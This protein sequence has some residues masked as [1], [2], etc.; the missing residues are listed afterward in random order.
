MTSQLTAR[1]RLEPYGRVLREPVLRRILI[2]VLVSGLG[3]GMAVVA[4]AWLAIQIAPV[5][6]R[7]L[8]TGA[9]VAAYAL[10]AALGAVVL[11]PF[12]RSLASS[13]L[14]ALDAILRAVALGAVAV[15]G[16]A[17]L[18]HPVV[19]VALLA[20][21]SLLHAWG[22]AGAYTLVSERLDGAD[23]VTGNALLSTASQASVVIGPA[24]AGG[25]VAIAGPAWVVGLDALS[26][27]ALAA[28]SWRVS[29]GTPRQ[30]ASGAGSGWRVIAGNRQLVGL[31]AITC[32]FYFLY[33]PVEVALPLHV[34]DDLRGSAG[35]LGL[36]L[37][38]F[39][40]GAL[41][42]GLAAGLLP[43]RSPWLV[44][45]VIIVGWGASLLPVGLTNTLLP[46]MI[47]LA[48]G[49]M[50]YGPYVAMSTEL[51]QR[52]SDPQALSRVLA[53]RTAIIIPAVS[54]GTLAGGPIVNA[55]GAQVTLT[56]S[57]VLTIV[58]GLVLGLA[59]LLRRR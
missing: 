26:F 37:A 1:T 8:W 31:L 12:V 16:I 13:R 59:V 33:G 11:A 41:I 54:L 4:V 58:L 7:G 17:G 28:V 23:R 50:I 3:D 39:G 19:Y 55:V 53:A 30:P 57:A 51:F 46:A 44:V 36:L 40:A 22:S 35:I 9:A 47:G 2:G 34:A 14:I 6:Q 45:V 18:L 42:G 15:L 32:A 38:V 10:P 21:S 52:S 56:A 48:F 20:I 5:S 29:S 27:V 25:I 43:R 49:G 24:L